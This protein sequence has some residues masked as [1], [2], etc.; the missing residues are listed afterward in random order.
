MV[1]SY[2]WTSFLCSLL[3][4]LPNCSF[5]VP[6]WHKS[7][8]VFRYCRSSCVPVCF[9]CFSTK[10]KQKP[11]IIIS[12]FFESFPLC[13]FLFYIRMCN[14]WWSIVVLAQCLT[15]RSEAKKL[16]L[17]H[18]NFPLEML[19]WQEESHTF[20]NFGTCNALNNFSKINKDHS[21]RTYAFLETKIGR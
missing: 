15:V 6:H 5:H 19:L 18:P 13:I 7:V 16:H 8:S 4:R 2:R 3:R 9:E 21:M 17:F 10:K 14:I 12:F 1:A 20:C 11:F